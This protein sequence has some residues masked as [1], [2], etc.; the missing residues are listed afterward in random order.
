MCRSYT[1][2]AVNEIALIFTVYNNYI[3]IYALF[4]VERAIDTYLLLYDVWNQS[5]NLGRSYIFSAD[6][7][8]TGDNNICVF[9]KGQKLCVCVGR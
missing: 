6:P 8:P 1:L 2:W 3:I 5:N 7:Q 4:I 9:I